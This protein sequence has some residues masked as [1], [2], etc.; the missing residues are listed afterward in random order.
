MW[1]QYWPLQLTAKYTIGIRQYRDSVGPY[2][3]FA[4]EL[5]R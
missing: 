2:T 1:F 3:I 5:V 4:H